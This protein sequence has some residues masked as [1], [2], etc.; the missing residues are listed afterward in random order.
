MRWSSC[1]ALAL[2]LL[3]AGPARAVFVPGE[4]EGATECWIGFSA[5]G[6]KPLELKRARRGTRI[7]QE[8]CA[9]ACDFSGYVCLNNPGCE[10]AAL[11]EVH[12]LGPLLL[13]RPKA[14]TPR[15]ACGRPR[16]LT[17]PL[18]PGRR[19]AR[20]KLVLM[21]RPEA[22]ARGRDVDV[23][24]LVCRLA[25]KGDTCARCGD[26]DVG[27]GEAC[28]DG[29]D[30]D[31][32]GC[33][34]NCTP[35]A[36]GNGARTLGEACDD[37]N[38]GD[39]DGC[40]RNCTPTACGN[41]VVTAG[42]QCD[43]P[44]RISDTEVCTAS[45]EREPIGPCT[46]PSPPG[47]L[48]MAT[49]TLADSCG[50]AIDEGGQPFAALGC[51][52]LYLG[53]GDAT[54]QQP[55]PIPEGTEAAFGVTCS[56]NLLR[57]G[58]TTEE[59]AGAP[60]RCTAAGCRFGPPLPAPNTLSASLSVCIVNTLSRA[61][62]GDAECDTGRV[63]EAKIPLV[64]RIF[65]TGEDQSPA[66]P[67]LQ[68]C[69]VCV[70]GRCRGGANQGGVCTPFAPGIATSYECPPSGVPLDELSLELSFSTDPITWTA[71]PSGTQAR[72]FCGYCR[73]ADL[74]LAFADP[75]IPC[76]IGARATDTCGVPSESCEQRQQG[77]FGP[78][79]GGVSTIALRGATGGRLTVGVPV[80]ATLASVFCVPPVAGD[81][82]NNNVS[83]PGPAALTL[84]V[85]ITPE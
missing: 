77:A 37:G 78:N 15:A 41:G 39:G 17:V 28:D 64:S 82:V 36:C 70:D 66:D 27:V 44:G 75:P 76:V 79:G 40:D 51:G 74:T 25:P 46:C 7:V 26:G 2:V 50:D 43:P 20:R 71:V 69:P 47:R 48:V 38:D 59:T 33:D 29:N 13:D 53:G 67:G 65:L 56:N 63:V 45:C 62:G 21:A 12:I 81:V 24:T 72:V 30:I 19:T 55:I 9:G 6:K 68:A 5:D 85:R 1:A 42:E 23:V 11:T 80:D 8:A 34:R 58:Q 61:V 18:A 31:G 57:L 54:V 60:N 14:V 10:A 35:T 52:G 73:D 4:G 32:D 84:P 22:P 83:L 16:P 49:R 3:A